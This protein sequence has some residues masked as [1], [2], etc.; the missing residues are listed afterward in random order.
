MSSQLKFALAF[1][2]GVFLWLVYTAFFSHRKPSDLERAA[3]YYGLSVNEYTSLMKPLEPGNPFSQ[4]DMDFLKKET[5]NSKGDVRG[6][7]F[8]ALA[9]VPAQYKSQAERLLKAMKDDKDPYV[10]QNAPLD[11]LIAGCPDWAQLAADYAR[12]DDPNLRQGA[13]VAYMK[14]EKLIQDAQKRA[15]GSQK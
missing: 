13:E 1:A 2:I 12:S 3:Q 14:E 4:E 8:S 11:L 9:R 7:A 15:N 5:Q 10:R 6:L